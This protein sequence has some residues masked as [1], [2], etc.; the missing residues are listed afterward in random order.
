MQWL[1]ERLPHSPAIA[2]AASSYRAHP[3]WHFAT[4]ANLS[5]DQVNYWINTATRLFV[6]VAISV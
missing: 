2:S 1:S 6:T 5:T 3:A 4:T